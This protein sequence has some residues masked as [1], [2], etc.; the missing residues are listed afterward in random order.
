MAPSAAAA[1]EV[2]AV[3]PAAVRRFVLHRLATLGPDANELARAVAVLG[4]DSEL[5]L[6]AGVAGLGEDAARAAADDLVRADIFVQDERL[7]FVHPIVR[8]ALYEDLAPGERQAR[9]AA[10][11]EA[12]AA[13]G[14][15]PERVTA[16]LLLTAATGDRRRVATLRS[17]AAAA[18]RGGAPA[19]AADAPAPGARRIARPSR[20]GRRSWPSS[21]ATRSPRCSSTRPRSICARR[22]PRAPSLATR[23]DAASMLGAL[24]DRLGRPLGGGRRRRAGRRSP[25]SFARSTRSA[26]S[27]WAPSC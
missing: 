19:A 13:A 14:A 4:D 26:R 16:H 27:S 12:L 21:A 24:R 3:G 15:S 6:A 18:A 10:A 7:G 8:A 22:W 5:P 9:H 1:S 20:S 23:A 17:A 11:A 2:Q 25:T